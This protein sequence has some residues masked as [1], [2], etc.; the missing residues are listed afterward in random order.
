V[1]VIDIFDGVWGFAPLAGDLAAVVVSEICRLIALAK[2]QIYCLISTNNN[3][4]MRL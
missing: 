2:L 3:D 4:K 1:F